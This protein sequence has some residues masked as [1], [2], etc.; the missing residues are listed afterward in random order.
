MGFEQ[1][2]GL[3]EVYVYVGVDHGH[4]VTLPM[5]PSRAAGTAEP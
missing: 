3:G 1:L 5:K 4:V 2:V